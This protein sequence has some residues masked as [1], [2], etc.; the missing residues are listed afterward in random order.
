MYVCNP[1]ADVI[2]VF[3]DVKAEPSL[4]RCCHVPCE[5]R[6]I[7]HPVNICNK[8]MLDIRRHVKKYY[9]VS[10]GGRERGR[11]EGGREGG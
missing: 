5:G 8:L 7:N 6:P 4:L 3:Q 9:S 10:T 11:R 2:F 1:V